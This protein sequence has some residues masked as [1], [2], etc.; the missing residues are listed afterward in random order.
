M[1]SSHL[2]QIKSFTNTDNNMVVKRLYM[3]TETV[4]QTQVSINPQRG[5]LN[6]YFTNRTS[7]PIIATTLVPMF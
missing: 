5:N 6:T 7:L 2:T 4:T 1:Y 3:Y